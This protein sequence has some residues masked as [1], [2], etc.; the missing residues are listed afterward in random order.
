MAFTQIITVKGADD[1]ALHELMARWDADQ[2]GVAPG[3]LG[4][5]VFADEAASKHLIEVDF[6]SEE[7]AR[8]NNDRPETETW[9]KDLRRLVQSEPTYQNLRQVCSTYVRT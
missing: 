3:Y 8:R 7:E 5:R 6:S 2:S 1:Q 4:C 9:A